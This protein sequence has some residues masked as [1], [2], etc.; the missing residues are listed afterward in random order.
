MIDYLA[1]DDQEHVMMAEGTA[2]EEPTIYDI[3]HAIN[4]RGF[5][6]QDISISRDYLQRMWR[7]GARII[8]A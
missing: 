8:K 5:S 2:N 3:T 4:E 6:V 7:F 1:I